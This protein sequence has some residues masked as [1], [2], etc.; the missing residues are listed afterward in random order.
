[1]LEQLLEKLGFNEKEIEVYLEVMLRGK[2][3]PAAVSRAV[4]INRA[5]V[6]SVAKNLIQKGV[7]SEDL[8]GKMKYLVAQPPEELKRMVEREKRTIER[9]GSVAEEAV[10]E[11]ASIPTGVQYAVPRMRFI[12]EEGVED[13]LYRQTPIWNQSMLRSKE[14]TLWGFQDDTF[15]THYADWI[16]WYWREAPAEI[17]LKLLSNESKVEEVMEEKQYVRRH[18]RFWDNRGEFTASTWVLGEYIVMIYTHERPFYAIELCNQVMAA[19][20]RMLFK[21]LWEK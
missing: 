12:E 7:I 19:N 16:D 18:I 5:T 6:Y 10:A 2:T 13:M 1:M 20:M 21:R 17:D 15:V 14:T 8:A 9:K 11:L 4:G 3:T